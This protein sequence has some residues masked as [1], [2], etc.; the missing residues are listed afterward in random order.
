MR[1]SYTV[2]YTTAPYTDA[3]F[4]ELNSAL[5]R[6]YA[7]RPRPD[8]WLVARLV[9]WRYGGNTVR[10]RDDPGFWAANACIFR[11]AAGALAGY[12]VSEYGRG[13]LFFQVDPA[14]R[15]VEPVMLAWVETIWAAGR[16]QVGVFA[17]DDDAERAA[18]LTAHGFHAHGSDGNMYRYDLTR[19]YPDAPLPAGF[20]VATLAENRDFA[21][22]AAVM[23]AAFDS[24]SI[25]AALLAFRQTAPGY[26][27]DWDLVAVAPDGRHA[28]FACAWIDWPNRI[29]EIEPVG[30]HPEFQRRGLAHALILAAYRRLA[31]AGIQTAYIGSGPEP[32]VGNCLYTAL[33]PVS[34][35][36]F[37]H[38]VRT[39]R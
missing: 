29:A 18:L 36:A 13:D 37:V 6:W 9:D 39:V 21:A 5:M 14:R 31:A 27:P 33:G 7:A 4:D 3:N 12:V 38:W 11:D 35:Q 17:L 16:D 26:S 34:R 24:P 22:Q 15:D 23:A 19:A 2:T 1:R 32:A 8:N 20:T 28:S 10:H 30:T 25:D